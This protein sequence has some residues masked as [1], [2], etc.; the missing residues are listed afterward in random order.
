MELKDLIHTQFLMENNLLCYEQPYYCWINCQAKQSVV[1]WFQPIVSLKILTKF[2]FKCWICFK[3]F[4]TKY[5][6][7]LIVVPAG[8]LKTHSYAYVT[9]TS[10]ILAFTRAFPVMNTWKHKDKGRPRGRLHSDAQVST[11]ARKHR[12]CIILLLC[13]CLAVQENSPL[14]S[15]LPC[16]F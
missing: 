10:K 16:Y 15:F 9:L 6:P 1:S 11:R 8:W 13:V 4:S 14:S 3:S 7:S 12:N 2:C 5:A